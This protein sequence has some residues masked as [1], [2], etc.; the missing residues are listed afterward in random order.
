MAYSNVQFFVQYDGPLLAT[1]GG[2]GLNFQPSLDAMVELINAAFLVLRPSRPKVSVDIRPHRGLG[3]YMVTVDEVSPPS[4]LIFRVLG[5]KPNDYGQLSLTSVMT[6][7]GF[8][9]TQ[10]LISLVKWLNGRTPAGTI[11]QPDGQVVFELLEDDW[12][13]RKEVSVGAAQLYAN[14]RML[15]LLAIVLE[16]L[17]WAAVTI[18]VVGRGVGL[19]AVITKDE[20]GCFTPFL[21]SE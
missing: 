20:V 19:Q 5:A 6:D 16:P 17:T 3:S 1:Q 8:N 7:L 10:G 2:A 9:A 14:P 18:W 13:I 4:S 15:Q 12:P 11:A 21:I